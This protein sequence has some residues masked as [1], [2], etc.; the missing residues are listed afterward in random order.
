M[1]GG[2]VNNLKNNNKDLKKSINFDDFD[3]LNIEEER[4][5]NDS[6]AITVNQ[7]ISNIIDMSFKEK[8]MMKVKFRDIV[9]HFHKI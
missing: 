9:I 2:K 7:S 1:D 8:R 6:I 5:A 3:N 4:N